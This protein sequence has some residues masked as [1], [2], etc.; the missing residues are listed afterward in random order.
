MKTG[1][2]FLL[3]VLFAIPAGAETYK[4]VDSRG[5]V[6]YTD[7]LG[8]IPQKYRKKAKIVGAEEEAVPSESGEVKEQPAKRAKQ[9]GEVVEQP[10]VVKKEQSKSYGGKSADTWR[11]EFG[12]LNADIKAAQE[13]REE[14]GD[15]MKDTSKM[16]R[17][18][19]L[20]IQMGINEVENRLQRLK[21]KR[22]ALIEE[23]NRADVPQGLRNP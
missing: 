9:G 5:N 2:I 13:Q 20:S 17:G 6:N 19:Y 14:L 7:D 8:N 4:W 21:A 11:R 23:A 1:I 10:A 12:Q 22:D 16:S 3:M 15:R 18:E